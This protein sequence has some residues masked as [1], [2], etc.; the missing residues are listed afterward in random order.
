[1]KNF[2]GVSG[3]GIGFVL[4]DRGGRVGDAQED[5][6]VEGA[7][8]HKVKASLVTV[9]QGDGGC[10]YRTVDGFADAVEYGAG[11]V[12]VVEFRIGQGGNL[13]I[14]HARFHGPGT[15]ETPMG[16]DHFLDHAFLDAIDRLETVQMLG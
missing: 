8:I 2:A 16:G 5:E 4:R 3:N 1:M 15:T 13:V 6:V 14:E 12:V 9:H 10:G 7:L 11:G